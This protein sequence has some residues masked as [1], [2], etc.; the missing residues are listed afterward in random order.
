MNLF[1]SSGL[2]PHKW[3]TEQISYESSIKEVL[4]NTIARLDS[5]IQQIKITEQSLKDLFAHMASNTG[6]TR[7]H[8]IKEGRRKA[9]HRKGKRL[10]GAA[11]VLLQAMTSDD[12]VNLCFP[13]E[14]KSLGISQHYVTAEQI[15]D[16]VLKEMLKKQRKIEALEKLR[17]L[18]VFSMDSLVLIES[19]SAMNEDSD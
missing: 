6:T 19:L 11:L 2:I 15:N 9:K 1:D 14:H 16:S 13:E 12:I 5:G 18:E 8:K 10:N 3:A 7:S 17:S 4:S